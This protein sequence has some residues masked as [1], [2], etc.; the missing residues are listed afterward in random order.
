MKKFIS[1]A[2]YFLCVNGYSFGQDVARD[3]SVQNKIKQINTDPK[4]LE[5]INGKVI[6]YIVRPTFFGT[7]IRQD[8]NCDNYFIG[9]TKGEEYL[10]TVILPGKH[11]F[12][13]A[14]E[15]TKKL[16]VILEAGKIYYIKQ[17]VKMGA[18]YAA[19]GLKLLTDEEGKKFLTKCK[20][21]KENTYPN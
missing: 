1:F 3:T 19:T 15:N 4:N 12:R 13:S 9:S 7:V 14:S 5:P 17:Q 11:I 2:I 10:Y 20:L 8:I 6:V 16:E 18:F 21:S